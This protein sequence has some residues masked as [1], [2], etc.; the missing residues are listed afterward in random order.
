MVAPAAAAVSADAPGTPAG[1]RGS[2]R[3]DHPADRH[4]HSHRRRAACRRRTRHRRQQA[5]RKRGQHRRLRAGADRARCPEAA[6]LPRHR[7]RPPGLPGQGAPP[8]PGP[9]P[10]GRRRP[11]SDRP[12]LSQRPD[13]S[14]APDQPDRP[15]RRAGPPRTRRRCADRT[16]AATMTGAREGPRAPARPRPFP[17]GLAEGGLGSRLASPREDQ[18]LARLASMMHARLPAGPRRHTPGSRPARAMG[19]R[20]LPRAGPAIRASPPRR[21][22]RAPGFRKSRQIPDKTVRTIGPRRNGSGAKRKRCARNSASTIRP[23]PIHKFAPGVGFATQPTTSAVRHCLKNN[24]D[25]TIQAIGWPRHGRP[26]G[27][28]TP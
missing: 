11:A 27:V 25:G 24:S 20:R 14:R 2:E 1:N 21:A 26:T 18:T 22:D 4:R 12:L 5:R 8:A 28:P 7:H 9:W 3:H 23:K 10:F 16:A 15:Q 19:I 17:A 13:P 6:G